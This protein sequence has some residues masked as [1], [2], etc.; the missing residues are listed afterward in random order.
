MRF[1][2]HHGNKHNAVTNCTVVQNKLTYIVL[3]VSGGHRD[4]PVLS[5]NIQVASNCDPAQPH[6]SSCFLKLHNTELFF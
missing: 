1:H 2:V 4:E 3:N 6:F 5:S